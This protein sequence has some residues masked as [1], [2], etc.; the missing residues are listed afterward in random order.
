MPFNIQ[1]P[2]TRPAE[3]HIPNTV[4]P[5]ISAEA[6]ANFVSSMMAV[7]PF[8][9]RDMIAMMAV[10]Y[11][12][13][14]GL[15]FD[16]VVEAMKTKANEINFKFVGHN[17]LWKDIIAISGKKDTPRVE[18]FTFCDAMVAREILDLSL[19][20]AVFLPCRVAV[21][22]DANKQIWVMTLDWDVRWLDSSKNPNQM[23]ASLREKSIAVR[24]AI[25]KIMRAGA[26]GEF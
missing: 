19:E 9:L 16:D 5:S 23:S 17:P 22:E 10:K 8:S 20:F 7:N 1:L 25:D 3:E 24:D 4:T 13:K 15:S 21:L 11:P 12:A 18:F 14:A 26:A 2:P 6:R